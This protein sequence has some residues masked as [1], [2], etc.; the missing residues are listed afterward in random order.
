MQ[1]GLGDIVSSMLMGGSAKDAAFG[2]EYLKLA[3]AGSRTAAMQKDAL[4]A[5]LSQDRL[6]ALGGLDSSMGGLAPIL[7]KGVDPSSALPAIASL[8]RASGGSDIASILGNMFNQF[9]LGGA[10]NRYDAGDPT[11]AAVQMAAGGQKMPD[12]AKVA[13]GVRYD[14]FNPA[15]QMT[16]TP[17]GQAHVNQANAAAG[18]SGSEVPLHEAQAREANARANAAGYL[19]VPVGND[20]VRVAPEAAARAAQPGGLTLSDAALGVLD[21]GAGVDPSLANAALPQG[22]SDVRVVRPA[23]KGADSTGS[24]KKQAELEAQGYSAD[25]ARGIAYGTLKTVA[26]PTGIVRQLVDTGSGHV[27][28]NFEIGKGLVLTPEGERLYAGKGRS[29]PAGI[30]GVLGPNI[31]IGG[32]QPSLEERLAKYRY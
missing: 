4:A 5:Q 8:V 3:T 30:P 32:K 26:D 16:L 17:L 7:P 21:G 12:L 9:R 22:A 24:A 29:A 10:V 28:A 27:I 11:G 15:G 18:A 31:N 14:P 25:L 23:S 2:D 13:D 20:L 19:S 1:K 6:N